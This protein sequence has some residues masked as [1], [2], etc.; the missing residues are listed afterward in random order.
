[1]KCTS[2]P[3][4]YLFTISCILTSLFSYAINSDAI[5]QQAGL[6]IK[7]LYHILNSR[8]NTSMDSR[9]D[10]FSNQFKGTRYI[11]GALGEGSNAQYDQYPTYRVDGFDCDTYVNTVL[12]LASASSLETFQQCLNFN[13][14][15]NGKI[16][17]I[18]RNHFTSL[19]WNRYNQQRGLLEDI[20]LKITDKQKHP[21]ALY[22][23][24]LINKPGWYAHK[25]IDTIRLQK[26]DDK[27]Q[28]KRLKELKAKGRQLKAITAQIPYIPL[29]ALFSQDGKPDYYMLSQIPNGAIIE[30]IRPNWDLREKIGTYLDVS[31]L[32]FAIWKKEQLFFREA[33]STYGSIVDVLLV[34]YLNDARKSP[35]IKGINVQVVKLKKPVSGKCQ[36]F[37]N[38]YL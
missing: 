22:A 15:K 6:T 3:F 11:L 37:V 5:E 21:V 13:R 14:Y 24:T 25:T 17:Y 16:S 18:N 8:P 31:H 34:D 12:A 33:S 35:T 23:K 19:D 10:W 20:T 1:M 27:E 26:Q 28:K 38:D 32:G 7:E 29:T 2:T 4:R 30:I 36:R 9:I